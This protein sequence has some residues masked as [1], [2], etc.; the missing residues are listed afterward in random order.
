[1]LYRSFPVFC[2]EKKVS[3]QFL[4][5]SFYMYLVFEKGHNTHSKDHST[6]EE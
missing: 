2:E 1:M 6:T 4:P 3:S 5:L